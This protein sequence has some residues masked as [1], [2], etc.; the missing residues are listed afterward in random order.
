MRE[1]F[2]KVEEVMIG[3]SPRVWNLLKGS[4]KPR[5]D[6]VNDT[7]VAVHSGL[8]ARQGEEE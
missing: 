6:E 8:R 3:T 5:M 7:P 1:A 2:A 4:D